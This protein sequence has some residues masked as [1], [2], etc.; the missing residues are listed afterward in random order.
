MPSIEIL[1]PIEKEEDIITARSKGRD[2][3][4]DIGFGPVDQARIP[5]AISELARNILVHAGSGTIHIR[6]I[7]MGAQKGIEVVAE[8]QG[9]GIEDLAM[10]LSDGYSTV[11][12]M[13]LG[14]PGA[15]RLMDEMEVRSR[16][17]EGTTVIARKWIR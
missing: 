5:T 2:L 13:G 11:G 3:A 1:V 17:G 6:S 7:D 14:L 16:P 15:K 12:S 4:R 9:P 8:D 10:A